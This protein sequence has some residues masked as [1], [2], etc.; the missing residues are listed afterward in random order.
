MPDWKIISDR[1][2]AALKLLPCRCRKRWED[3]KAEMVTTLRCQRC[4]AVELY[5][6][7]VEVQA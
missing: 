4:I 2:Y 7:A 3:G 5:E 6:Q 1:L